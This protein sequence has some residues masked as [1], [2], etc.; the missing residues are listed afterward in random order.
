MRENLSSSASAT[1]WT[2]RVLAR[3]G[4]P[5]RRAWPPEKMAVRI[6]SSTFCCP[7][8]RRPTWARRSERADARRSRRSTSPEGGEEG[9]GTGDGF[10]L[11]DRKRYHILLPRATKGCA[12]TG[13][14]RW[15][16]SEERRVGKECRSRWSPYH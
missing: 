16:R 7:T 2:I 8:M 6:P 9:R 10:E 14:R 15:G 4:T 12:P 1:V 13:E 5:T 3:P 11:M